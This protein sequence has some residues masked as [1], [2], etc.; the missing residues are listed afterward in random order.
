MHIL[1]LILSD[2]DNDILYAI[3]AKNK[4]RLLHVAKS[5]LGDRAEDAVHDAFLSLAEKYESK[6]EELCDKQ[7]YFFVTIVKNRSIDILRKEQRV[8]M[9]D[10]DEEGSVF[11]DQSKPLDQQM[12]N[13][14]ALDRLIVHLGQLKPRFREIVEYKYLLEYSNSE[15]AK[16]LG[17]SPSLV[18]TRLQRALSQLRERFEKEGDK[19]DGSG[20]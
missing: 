16:E 7:D 6:I 1:I 17:I 15:I 5:Y 4:K 3:Y 13:Q 18:S 12:A 19:H 20:I 14:E 2:S 10:I 11:A 8:E 9:I